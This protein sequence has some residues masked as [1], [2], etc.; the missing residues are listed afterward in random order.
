MAPYRLVTEPRD[1]FDDKESTGTMKRIRRDEPLP[2]TLTVSDL[3][4]RF[5]DLYDR[6]TDIERGLDVRDE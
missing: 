6:L 5:E 2:V 3:E 1:N 4:R